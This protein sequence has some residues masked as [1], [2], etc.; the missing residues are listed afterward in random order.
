MLESGLVPVLIGV[1]LERYDKN[2][3]IADRTKGSTKRPYL[4]LGMSEVGAFW[5]VDFVHA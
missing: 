1:D 5:A 2:G 4:A 3:F